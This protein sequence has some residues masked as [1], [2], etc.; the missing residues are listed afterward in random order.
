[1]FFCVCVCV[2]VMDGK[3]RW[4]VVVVVVVVGYTKRRWNMENTS[5]ICV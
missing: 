3:I 1:M 2:L 5:A 4:V